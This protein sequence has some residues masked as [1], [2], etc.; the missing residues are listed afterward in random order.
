MLL[1]RAEDPWSGISYTR[2]L[3]FI[4]PGADRYGILLSLAEQLGLNSAVLSINGNR[5]FF[6]FPRGQKIASTGRGGFPFN[7][8]SPVI[9][10]AHYDRV[11]G[12]PGANDNSAAVFHLLKTALDLEKRDAGY[13]IIIF[14]DKEELAAGEGI[15]DQ[16][17]FTLAEKLKLWGLGNSRVFILDA[18]GSGDTLII[19]NTTDYLLKNNERPGILKIRQLIQDLRNQA[20]ETVL[21]AQDV[22]HPVTVI[23]GQNQG[24]DDV[25]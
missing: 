13:W 8:Q 5:H 18:C 12:S 17:S 1:S 23:K 15:R 14:T 21:D 3:N 11:P 19:S 20:L 24:P 10:A 4:A 6:I 9:L 22:S 16:G 2:F 25:V 7:G